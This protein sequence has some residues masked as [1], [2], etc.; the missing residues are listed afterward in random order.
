M[1]KGSLICQTWNP[2]AFIVFDAQTVAEINVAL[3]A[4]EK[5]NVS[6]H[7]MKC[8]FLSFIKIVKERVIDSVFGLIYRQVFLHNYIYWKKV[9]R[10]KNRCFIH[11]FSLV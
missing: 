2:V 1:E 11:K 6:L 5:F 3:G 8:I 10:A 9:L 4:G 7:F